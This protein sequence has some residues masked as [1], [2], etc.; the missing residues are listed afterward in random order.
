MRYSE[1]YYIDWKLK[2]IMNNIFPLGGLVVIL[3]GDPDQLPPIKGNCL[4]NKN[5]MN[6][7]DN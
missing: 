4:W 3:D 2:Q 7:S 5:C 1:L 6:S